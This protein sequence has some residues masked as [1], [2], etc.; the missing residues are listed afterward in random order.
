MNKKGSTSIFLMMV[1]LFLGVGYLVNKGI[2]VLNLPEDFS[3]TTS[4]TSKPVTSTVP[5]EDIEEEFCQKEG[6]DVKLSL[7]EAKEIAILGECGKNLKDTYI[8]NEV[9]G[10][11]WINLDIEKEGCNPACVIDVETKMAEINWRCTGLL[12]I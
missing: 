12:P 7:S 9:T 2:I 6:T 11:W 5:S 1:V 10:T 3:M 4:S 8:C